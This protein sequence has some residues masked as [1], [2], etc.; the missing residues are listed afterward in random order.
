MIHEELSA[1]EEE[2]EL[3]ADEESPWE[4]MAKALHRYVLKIEKE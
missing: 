1:D 4:E 3:L 2:E